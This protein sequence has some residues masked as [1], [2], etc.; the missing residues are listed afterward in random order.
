MLPYYDIV[1]YTIVINNS[2]LKILKLY[3]RAKPGGTASMYSSIIQV[4][5]RLPSFPP[6]CSSFLISK[7]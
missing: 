6:F 3:L 7:R 1:E 2:N 5:K 4:L